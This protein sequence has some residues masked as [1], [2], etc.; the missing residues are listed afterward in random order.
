METT[1]DETIVGPKNYQPTEAVSIDGYQTLDST[2]EKFILA[3]DESKSSLRLLNLQMR[4][5]PFY[6]IRS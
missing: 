6:P 4:Y 2:D 3:V 5:T 1:W